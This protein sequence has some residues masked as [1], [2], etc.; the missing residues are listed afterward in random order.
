MNFGGLLLL[1]LQICYCTERCTSA[2]PDND[3][4]EQYKE[5]KPDSV[6][7]SATRH[8]PKKSFKTFL[9]KKQKWPQPSGE[10][11]LKRVRKITKLPTT[12]THCKIFCRSGY[13][14]Q[15]LPN[16]VVKGTLDQD[17]KY[18]VFEMQSF[19]TS[20]VRLKS[21]TTG[22]Y[23]TMRRN[24]T[25]RGLKNLSEQGGEPTTNSTHIWRRRRW[26]R[27]VGQTCFQ[28]L[29]RNGQIK[30][31]TKTLHGQTATQFLVIKL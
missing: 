15:I 24:G 11:F 26:R 27:S 23:L 4:K 29:E 7:S 17:S 3:T 8:K 13:H 28:S 10:N 5:G 31:A 19:G 2:K 6:P 30:R 22:R 9:Y 12:S 25:L 20:L 1:M 18:V 21:I 14:L 16:G